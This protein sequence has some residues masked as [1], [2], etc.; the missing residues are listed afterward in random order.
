M[1]KIIKLICFSLVF[2]MVTHTGLGVFA[3][4][5]NTETTN[6]TNSI[7]MSVNTFG[8][9]T[10]IEG[11]S[12]AGD[13][14][15]DLTYVVMLNGSI[16]SIS[17]GKTN[18]DGSFEK[19]VILDTSLYTTE[20]E[21]AVWVSG[22][23]VNT[24]STTIPLYSKSVID[25]IIPA[26]A[27]VATLEDYTAFLESYKEILGWQELSGYEAATFDEFI[28]TRPQGAGSIEDLA[29]WAVEF[30]K[31]GQ[32]VIEFLGKINEASENERWG[33]IQQIVTDTYKDTLPNLAT[34][35]L[36]GISSLKD[37]YMRMTKKVYKS[38][39]EVEKAFSD[40]CDAQ[41]TA[42][43]GGNGGGGSGGGG[44][45]KNPMSLAPTVSNVPGEDTAGTGG[46][47]PEDVKLPETSFDDLGSVE[48]AEDAINALRERGVVYGNGNGKY[49][50][51]R[52]IA[53]EEVV[54]MLTRAFQ[55][56]EA[57]KQEQAFVDVPDDAWFKDAVELATAI[58][59]V[60]G[61]PDGSFGAGKSITRSELIV[62]AS[63]ML[64][65]VGFKLEQKYPAV[66]FSDFYSIPDYAIETISAMQ[67]AGLING[68]SSGSVRP[69]DNASRAEVAVV[70]Y[71]LIEAV[72]GGK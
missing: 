25:G 66:V 45:S 23:D 52:S 60:N 21:A 53:R 4:E 30:L 55:L 58:G 71:S 57:G 33:V 34:A 41:K 36:E 42:E 28:K 70:I 72:E 29:D 46:I 37:M 18:A 26:I 5:I 64:S 16:L 54:A 68:D 48:W 35:K 38:A 11:K 65:A 8:N 13:T 43:S 69:L 3:A 24:L 1:R 51:E 50:P 27:A 40:A 19:R 44:G 14:D 22:K 32:R 17:Q 59:L 49:E 15:L 61:Y 56:P 9:I 2:V 67:Q 39:A 31:Y 7:E 6:R 62:M 10:T 20:T 63:R 12:V 47:L